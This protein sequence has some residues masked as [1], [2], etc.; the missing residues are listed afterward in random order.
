MSWRRCK[1]IQN[2]IVMGKR[3]GKFKGEEKNRGYIQKKHDI[4]GEKQVWEKKEKRRRR[5][6]REEEE[7]KEKDKK[8]K[9]RI[10]RKRE[11]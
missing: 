2:R 10:R 4:W 6:K 7:G 5:R 1:G 9:R 11:G 8:E 3:K